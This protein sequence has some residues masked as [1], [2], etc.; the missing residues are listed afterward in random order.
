M[1]MKNVAGFHS[2]DLGFLVLSLL[3]RRS[4]FGIIDSQKET[5]VTLGN[6]E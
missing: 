1:A 6:D 3:P 2:V 4:G 5:W